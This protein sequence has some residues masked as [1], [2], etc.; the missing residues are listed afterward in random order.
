M[1]SIGVLG[2]PVTG[3]QVL[4][5]DSS[6]FEEA[7]LRACDLVLAGDPESAKCRERVAPSH[8]RLKEN[9]PAPRNGAP[10]SDVVPDGVVEA[11]TVLLTAD[12][13]I[14]PKGRCRLIAPVYKARRL[15]RRILSTSYP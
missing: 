1:R 2:K 12:F 5:A 3:W 6:D 14:P 4:P 10:A 7:A 15:V 11:G 13:P 8:Q 9:Q